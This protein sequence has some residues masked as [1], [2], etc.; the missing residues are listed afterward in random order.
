MSRLQV[1]HFSIRLFPPSCYSGID[2][3]GGRPFLGQTLNWGNGHDY[4]MSERC[5]KTLY[6]VAGVW[7][8]QSIDAR[9][10]Y[11]K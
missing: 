7:N 3:S 11:E 8:A 2:L 9:I 1:L 6:L 5:V 10:I 4:Q